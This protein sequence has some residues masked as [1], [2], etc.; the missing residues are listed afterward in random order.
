M[1]FRPLKI[2]ERA[3]FMKN[4]LE[5]FYANMR[6]NN[7]KDNSAFIQLAQTKVDKL[8]MLNKTLTDEQKALLEAYFDA[9]TQIQNMIDFEKFQYAFHLGAQLMKELIEGKNQFFNR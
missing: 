3:E 5:L 7:H 9:D 6:S 8:E 4:I 1:L 2:I